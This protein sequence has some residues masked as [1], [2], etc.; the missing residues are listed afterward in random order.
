MNQKVE[1]RF[2]TFYLGHVDFSRLNFVQKKSDLLNKSL[3]VVKIK[4]VS[5]YFVLIIYRIRMNKLVLP[6]TILSNEIP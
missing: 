5:K 6:R 4:K 2:F 1:V 3:L